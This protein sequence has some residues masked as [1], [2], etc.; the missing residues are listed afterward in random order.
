MSRRTKS[1]GAVK[2]AEQVFIGT[3]IPQDWLP[4]IDSLIRHQDTDRSKFFRRA[5][6]KHADLQLN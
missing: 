1:R 5:L 3:W 6:A 4:R 2:R